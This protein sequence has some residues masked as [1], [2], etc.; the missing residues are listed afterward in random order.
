LFGKYR[1]KVLLRSMINYKER[2][3]PFLERA[4]KE[5]IDVNYG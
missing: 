1:K 5:G 3:S 4:F 2:P